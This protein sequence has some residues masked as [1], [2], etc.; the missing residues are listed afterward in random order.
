MARSSC[1]R[2]P[3]NEPLLIIRKWQVV[4]CE[5]NTCA[6]SLL[7]LFEYWY[8]IKLE[9][10]KQAR[11]ANAI[12]AR[13]GDI[14]AQD[15]GLANFQTSE[16]LVRGLLGL[17]KADSIRQAIKYLVRRG[18]IQQ[19]RNRNPRYKFDKTWHFLFCVDAVQG[20]LDSY[21]LSMTNNSNAEEWELEE[22]SLINRESSPKI[23]A[24]CPEQPSPT[25]ESLSGASESR[26]AIPEIATKI[27]T[28][29]S[30]EKHP[31]LAPPANAI[32]V[33]GWPKP[34][35]VFLHLA[36]LHGVDS[37]FCELMY[38]DFCLWRSEK[39]ERYTRGEWDSKF[40]QWCAKKW[41]E[42]INPQHKMKRGH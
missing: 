37:S 15:E 33:D 18:F 9:K 2:H 3:A 8:S 10:R 31:P 26:T 12:A 16:M 11:H 23:P 28:E 21:L 22:R 35:Q 25:F 42:R 14:G 41:D 4:V 30:Q 13:H 38:I 39:S 6:A 29:I 5:G 27:T 36:F 1:I 7:S 40:L 32:S 19:F 24:W 20:A 34:E 17:Y